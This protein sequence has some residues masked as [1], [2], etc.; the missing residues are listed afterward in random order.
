VSE[1]NLTNLKIAEKLNKILGYAKGLNAEKGQKLD[2][3]FE[4]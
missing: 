4:N 3:E 2:A 1:S